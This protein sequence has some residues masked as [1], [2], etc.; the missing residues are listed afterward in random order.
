MYAYLPSVVGVEVSQ[1]S[2]NDCFAAIDV[3]PLRDVLRRTSMR[4]SPR[5]RL[6]TV[7][8]HSPFISCSRFEVVASRGRHGKITRFL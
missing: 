4:I 6:V 8:R 1:V 3:P 5:L 7:Y 2:T